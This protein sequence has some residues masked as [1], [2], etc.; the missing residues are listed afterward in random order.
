MCLQ[1]RQGVDLR[2]SRC[3][4][5]VA[6]EGGIRAGYRITDNL[7]L[8]LTPMV[9]VWQPRINGTRYNN[10]HFVGVGRLPVGI[11]YRF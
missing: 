3:S 8:T 4:A 10:H 6:I 2:S 5:S 9:T 11:S 7:D 1:A